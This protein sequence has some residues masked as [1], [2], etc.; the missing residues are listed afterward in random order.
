MRP[1]VNISLLIVDFVDS[2][3]RALG[4]ALA[5]GPLI[6]L[7]W[8]QRLVRLSRLAQVLDQLRSAGAHATPIVVRVI[9]AYPIAIGLQ[10]PYEALE[11]SL[12]TGLRRCADFPVV[13]R[14]GSHGHSFPVAD[15]TTSFLAIFVDLCIVATIDRML[16]IIVFIPAIFI[17]L[18][19]FDKISQVII[20]HTHVVLADEVFQ[21]HG[22]E[23]LLCLLYGSP[24]AVNC[25]KG[26]ELPHPFHAAIVAMFTS[27]AVWR[28]I[29]KSQAHD[30]L[31]NAI[32]FKIG[33]SC[34]AMF[35]VA[36][37]VVA[38]GA[39]AAVTTATIPW[40]HLPPYWSR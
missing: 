3:R 20:I 2:R 35:N 34:T 9:G 38:A 10:V 36:A 5:C 39:V 24:C 13:A 14:H 37:P 26:E 19:V 30:L 15:L 18:F 8:P 6:Q 11:V 23:Q 4:P 32:S 29:A 40:D 22:S 12:D 1:P 17:I 21:S 7:H 27:A 33:V 16:A 28:G 31:L 25:L